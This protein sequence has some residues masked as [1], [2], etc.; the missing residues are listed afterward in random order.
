MPVVKSLPL[1]IKPGD[2][3]KLRAF[4]SHS[5]NAFFAALAAFLLCFSRPF[6]FI[7]LIPLCRTTRKPDVFHRFL[8]KGT[9]FQ[10]AICL[11]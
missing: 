1:E 9:R 7:F 10:T 11:A 8:E 6:L 2:H 5:A 3:V 4:T